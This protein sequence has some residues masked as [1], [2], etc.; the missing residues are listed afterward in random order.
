MYSTEGSIACSCA[1]YSNASSVFLIGGT[2]FGCRQSARKTSEGG[3]PAYRPDA[4][5]HVSQTKSPLSHMLG[6]EFGEGALAKVDMEIGRGGDC[7]GVRHRRRVGR[8][9]RTSTW[10]DS[11]FG[12]R[13][14]VAFIDA[15]FTNSESQIRSALS[16]Y[17]AFT[18]G[19]HTRQDMLLAFVR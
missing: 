9:L 13:D 11:V 12:A 14:F 4:H 17:S 3:R 7:E 6:D 16:K 2:R 1:L 18:R 15:R 8:R 19:R 5:H 10:P